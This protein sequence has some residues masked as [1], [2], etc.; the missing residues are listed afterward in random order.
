MKRPESQLTDEFR[1]WSKKRYYVR[2]Y[3]HEVLGIKN[4]GAQGGEKKY[5]DMQN[6]SYDNY[7]LYGDRLLANAI[8]DAMPHDANPVIFCEELFDTPAPFSYGLSEPEEEAGVKKKSPAERIKALV[9]N[10]SDE[11]KQEFRDSLIDD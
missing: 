6:G 10:M 1:H 11:E 4:Y 9:R 8:L 2:K 7:Q 3:A 5:W